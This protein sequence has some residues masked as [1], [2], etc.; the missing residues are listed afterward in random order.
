MPEVVWKRQLPGDGAAIRLLIFGQ[1]GQLQLLSTQ[2]PRYGRG[3]MPSVRQLSN[4]AQ[5]LE[6]DYAAEL[7]APSPRFPPLAAAD[8]LGVLDGMASGIKVLHPLREQDRLLPVAN[9]FQLMTV[10]LPKTAKI[11]KEAK[12]L[13]QEIVSE[14]IGC[15]TSEANDACI[16]AK[17]KAITKEQIV[18]ALENLGACP[19]MPG[20]RE[21][22]FRMTHAWS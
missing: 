13:T 9:I 18:E 7:G 19:S 1:L 2:G 10:E 8:E 6:R 5:L 4:L 22:P 12:L 15:I 3:A 20:P 21:G 14:F 11:S 16:Q 17:K